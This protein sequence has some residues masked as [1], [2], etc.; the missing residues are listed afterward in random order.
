[1]GV[2]NIHGKRDGGSRARVNK[3]RN[4]SEEIFG[5]VEGGV[6][7]GRPN[8]RL[9]RALESIC[10]RGQVTSCPTEK[11]PVKVQHPKKPLESRLVRRRREGGNGGGVLRERGTT[12]GREEMPKKLAV[13]QRR[14]T[15]QRLP[16]GRRGPC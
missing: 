14:K 5:T 7:S 13:L 10:E 6:Q 9:A 11:L 1:M 4:G 3:P 8:Q 12:R 15:S 16:N 2:R